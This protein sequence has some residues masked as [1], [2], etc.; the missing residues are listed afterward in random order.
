MM[1]GHRPIV[2]HR[3]EKRYL[4]EHAQKPI[5]FGLKVILVLQLAA[6][7][8]PDIV[9]PGN[10]ICVNCYSGNGR[11]IEYRSGT[12]FSAPIVSGVIALCRKVSGDPDQIKEA[13]QQSAIKLM[14]PKTGQHY[15]QKKQ[16]FGRINAK[17]GL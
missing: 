15:E 11:D 6:T 4:L 8:K 3:P 13:L 10:G 9:A 17:G 1:K 16:G 7:N 14:D 12:S 2:L 5:Q